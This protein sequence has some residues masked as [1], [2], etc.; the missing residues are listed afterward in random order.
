MLDEAPEAEL[1]EALV[2]SDQA[3]DQDEIDGGQAGPNAV[4]CDTEGNGSGPDER[5]DADER[6][7]AGAAPTPHVDSDDLPSPSDST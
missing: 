6:L 3:G 4:P 7:G 2:L 1:D 5:L